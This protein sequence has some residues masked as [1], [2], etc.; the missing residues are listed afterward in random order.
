MIIY[1]TNNKNITD[2]IMN[3]IAILQEHNLKVTPQRLEIVDILYK[4]GHINIDDLYKSL[5]SKFPSL[6]LATVY[7]NINTMCG[8]FFLSEVKLPNMKS[9][10]ELVKKEHSHVVCSKCNAI[11]DIDIDTSSVFNQ[12]KSK[13]NY[14]L[15]ESAIVFNGICP[16]CSK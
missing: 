6:S 15:N 16:D 4:N 10:Y 1:N 11:M 2:K 5:Q 3:Y 8:K 9:V 14:D 7:K 12:A 13:S